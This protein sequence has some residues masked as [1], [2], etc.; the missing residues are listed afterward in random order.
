MDRLAATIAT[1]IA[2]FVGTNLDDMV[3]L[4]ALNFS[5]QTDGRPAAWQ[6]WTGQYLGIAV[7]V[8]VSVLAAQGLTLLPENRMWILGLV[9]LGLGS[10]KLFVTLRARGSGAPPSIA[11]ANGLAGVIAVTIAN[12]G[13][14]VAAYAPVFRTSSVRDIAVMIGVFAIGVAV[15]C[16]AGSWLVSHRTITQAIQRWGHWGVPVVFILIGVYIFYKAGVLGL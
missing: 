12:G 8:G 2:L 11:V 14:N 5:S 4:A 9:P 13:D 3:V 15:W 16:A 1:A 7:L 10:W 6:I